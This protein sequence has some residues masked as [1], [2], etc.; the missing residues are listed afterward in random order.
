MAHRVRHEDTPPVVRQAMHSRIAALRMAR[1]VTEV[2]HA[3]QLADANTTLRLAL[4]TAECLASHTAVL[5]ERQL[6]TRL[7]QLPQIAQYLPLHPW[8][9]VVDSRP[10]AGAAADSRVAAAVAAEVVSLV[11]EALLEVEEAMA[12]KNSGLILKNM[13]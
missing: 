4:P 10:A 13:I 12:S 7:V 5:L 1:G 8:E 6:P 3:A 2:Q 11:E 9:A